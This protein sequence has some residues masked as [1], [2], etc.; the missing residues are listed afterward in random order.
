MLSVELDVGCFCVKRG[1]V[2]A[3]ALE[4]YK[5]YPSFVRHDC[6]GNRVQTRSDVA[7]G[8]RLRT[9]VN[10][11]NVKSQNTGQV[12]PRFQQEG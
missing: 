3:V 2:K 5:R 4:E 11:Y 1:Q 7:A 8:V 10:R 12:C 9:R 6:N